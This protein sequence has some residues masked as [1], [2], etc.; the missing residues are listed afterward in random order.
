GDSEELCLIYVVG[1]RIESRY[2]GDVEQ[3]ISP[4]Q[5]LLYDAWQACRMRLRNPHIVQVD[6]PRAH[7]QSIVSNGRKAS[8]VTRALAISPLSEL[9]GLQLGR[10]GTLVDKLNA[11]ERLAMLRATEALAVTT[12]EAVLGSKAPQ[13]TGNLQGLY[14][15]AQRYIRAHLDM[16]GLNATRIAARLGC[17]RTMLYRAFGE[18]GICIAQHIRE[19]RLQKLARLLQSPNHGKTIAQLAHECGLQDSPNVSRL[20]LWR[21]GVSPRDFRRGVRID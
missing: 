8:E 5:F 1:G 16:A 9:L 17:S 11:T 15:L 12:L 4:G 14:E 20:F 7:L 2:E 21:F 10:F 19:L 13:E 18:Q 3:V 6:L